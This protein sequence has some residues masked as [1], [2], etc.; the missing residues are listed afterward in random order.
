MPFDSVPIAADTRAADP[1]PLLLEGRGGPNDRALFAYLLSGGF[2]S[3]RS[4]TVEVP[5][6][7]LALAHTD[8]RA[9]KVTLPESCHRLLSSLNWWAERGMRRPA[10][11]LWSY[12]V[13]R[14][15]EGQAWYAVGR[16][17]SRYPSARAGATVTTPLGVRLSDLYVPL[18]SGEIREIVR[19]AEADAFDTG[20]IPLTVERCVFAFETAAA[21]VSWRSGPGR[22]RSSAQAA[23]S[24]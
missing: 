20:V 5:R 23:P 9:G 10:E 24:A 21:M 1:V 19:I 7:N 3:V 6:V 4:E 17:G 22:A 11:R 14:G 15:L 12:C 8:W 2:V 13:S 16:S 18:R